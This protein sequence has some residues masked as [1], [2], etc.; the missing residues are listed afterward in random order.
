LTTLPATGGTYYFSSSTVPYSA[1][2]ST[3]TAEGCTPCAF[4]S[5]AYTSFTTSA[6]VV[7]ANTN[8]ASTTV[9]GTNNHIYYDIPQSGRDIDACPSMTQYSTE[10]AAGGSSDGV[11][12]AYWAHGRDYPLNTFSETHTG[13]SVTGVVFTSSTINGT[14]YD[15]V[16]VKCSSNSSTSPINI[17]IVVKTSVKSSCEWTFNLT[18][19]GTSPS[20]DCTNVTW[21]GTQEA[22]PT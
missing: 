11:I 15:V 17:K 16:K 14:S 4:Q 6:V 12:V 9:R 19:A 2:T 5:T 3:P 20:C 1:Y 7:G 21:G 10:I 18:Q 22:D 13:S 8:T